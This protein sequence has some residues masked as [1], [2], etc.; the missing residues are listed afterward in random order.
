MALRKRENTENIKKYQLA[1][2]GELTLEKGMDVIIMK[3][4]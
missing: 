1:H 3:P 4:T 2:S